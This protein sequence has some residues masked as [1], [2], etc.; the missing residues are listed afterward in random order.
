M[1]KVISVFNSKGGGAKTTTTVNLAY[2]LTKLNKKVL[3]VDFDPQNNAS[4]LT[5]I[6][7]IVPFINIIVLYYNYQS[8]NRQSKNKNLELK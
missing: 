7:R 1:T 5:N 3:I 8:I 6:Y 2:N 4:I